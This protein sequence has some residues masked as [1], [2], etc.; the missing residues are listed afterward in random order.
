[1][2]F[3][4]LSPFILLFLA[5]AQAGGPSCAPGYCL[6][7]DGDGCHACWPG[8]GARLSERVSTV[9]RT[10]TGIPIDTDWKE[11]IYA[12]A[13]KNVVHPSWAG[14]N[15]CICGM[16]GGLPPPP[17]CPKSIANPLSNTPVPIGKRT[18]TQ[19]P[20]RSADLIGESCSSLSAQKVAP[21]QG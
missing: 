10:P 7:A 2:R 11:Q 15:P 14:C 4:F 16:G 12:F 17:D 18:K 1:M 21:Q 9:P 3:L 13:Q 8:V 19:T 5:A 20:V 6:D